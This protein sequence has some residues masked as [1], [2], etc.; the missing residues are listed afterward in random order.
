MDRYS[1]AESE[2]FSSRVIAL[3][4]LLGAALLPMPCVAD[5]EPLMLQ[6]VGQRAFDGDWTPADIMRE[7]SLAL[8]EADPDATISFRVTVE[9]L[10]DGQSI[11]RDDTGLPVARAERDGISDPQAVHQSRLVSVPFNLS[12]FSAGAIVDVDALH[13]EADTVLQ[14]LSLV[15]VPNSKSK[16]AISPQ[17]VLNMPNCGGYGVGTTITDRF[18]SCVFGVI[19][20]TFMC[21]PNGNG[22]NDW[23]IVHQELFPPE[24]ACINP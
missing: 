16:D 23:Y 8:L 24:F 22:G 6:K 17:D 3:T 13:F 15:A 7:R 21:Q 5:Q 1:T 20:T 18:S 12:D 4:L 2:R 9:T 19:E 14:R 11:V 10:K